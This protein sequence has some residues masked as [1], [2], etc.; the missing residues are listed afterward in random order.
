MSEGIWKDTPVLVTGGGGFLGS[1]LVDALVSRGTRVTVV[2]YA[3]RPWRLRH[4]SGRITCINADLADPGW[5]AGIPYA[6]QRVF[7]LAA[8]SQL[9]AAEKH[10]EIAFRQNVLATANVLQLARQWSVKKFIFTSAG[11]LYTNV[12]KYLPI[13]EDHPIDPGQG[14]YVMTKRIGELLCDDFLR[15]CGVPSLYF[16]L[17]NTYGPRQSTDFLI[18]SL[19]KQGFESRKVTVRTQRVKRDFSFVKDVVEALIKGAESDYCGGPLNLGT[20]VDHSLMDLARKIAA[21]LGAELECLNEPTFGPER[22]VCDS[23][24]ARRVLN[25]QPACTLD[26]GLQITIE[27]FKRDLQ[28]MLK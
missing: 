2:D 3:E 13:D 27:S 10:P 4:L 5:S 17:F 16:R 22:Q 28:F 26:E 19:I 15:Q 14:I 18:P 6:F 11:G 1:H 20:G 7:H 25:W 12:P 21:L 24:L 23:R 9:S 8:F